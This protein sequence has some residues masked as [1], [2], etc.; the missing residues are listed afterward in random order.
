MQ[1]VHLRAAIV[2]TSRVLAAVIGASLRA[3]FVMVIT[4]VEI[5]ATKT[6]RS[7]EQT[8]YTQSIIPFT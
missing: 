5:I 8:V 7:A 2:N 4:T 1:R 3:I 6:P